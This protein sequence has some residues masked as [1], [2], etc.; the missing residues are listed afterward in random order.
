MLFI[1]FALGP[2][3]MLKMLSLP[4]YC[5]LTL[6]LDSSFPITTT[7]RTEIIINIMQVIMAAT[8]ATNYVIEMW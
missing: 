4:V 1:G 2:M 6:S 3:S 7:A 5:L 8:M